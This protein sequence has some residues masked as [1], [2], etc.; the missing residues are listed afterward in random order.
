M[1]CNIL[2]YD[3][4]AN[5]LH[6]YGSRAFQSNEQTTI[7]HKQDGVV[8]SIIPQCGILFLFWFPV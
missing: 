4:D 2:V 7:L 8:V 1:I 3:N 5:Q 6:V